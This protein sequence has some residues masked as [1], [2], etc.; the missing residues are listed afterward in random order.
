M[1]QLGYTAG[2]ARYGVILSIDGRG[3]I[4]WHM[5][6]GILRERRGC[7]PALEK[8]GRCSSP[9]RTSWMMLPARAVLLRL[10]RTSRSTFPQSAGAA[11]ALAGSLGG[12]PKKGTFPL[13]PGLRQSIA[14]AEKAGPRIMKAFLAGAGHCLHRLHRRASRSRGGPRSPAAFRAR[15]RLQ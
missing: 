8:Q 3:T 7:S 12:P 6:A 13:P 10:A 11:R 15:C 9:W 5:P 2:E 1:I 14:L 4:T